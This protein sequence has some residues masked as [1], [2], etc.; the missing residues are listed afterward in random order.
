MQLAIMLAR[1]QHRRIEKR[2]SEEQKIGAFEV[3]SE[4]I[5]EAT[6]AIVARL[7]RIYCILQPGKT[8]A[9]FS[10]NVITPFTAATP[11]SP[12]SISFDIYADHSEQTYKIFLRSFLRVINY[13]GEATAADELAQQTKAWA[14]VANAMYQLGILENSLVLEPAVGQ[15]IA[16]RNSDRAS[17]AAKGRTGKYDPLRELA[18]ELAKKKPFTS[19]RQAALSMKAEILA[20][21]KRLGM[22]LSEPQAE[23]TITGWLAG[24]P[25]AKQT[26][27]PT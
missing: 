4:S 11:D 21:A 24:I 17:A 12:P 2:M 26:Q 23:R 5:D 6:D 10:A 3:P 16:S 14:Q 7:A 15:I 19:R 13:V 27:T 22:S 8:L 18:Q 1:T 9:D 20:E 25:F